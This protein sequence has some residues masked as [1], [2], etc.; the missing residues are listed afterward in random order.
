MIIKRRFIIVLLVLAAAFVALLLWW[1][2]RSARRM[3]DQA[4]P[5][6][7]P[8]AAPQA[9]G[10]AAS[11][12]HRAPQTEQ[13]SPS[14][15]RNWDSRRI[16]E[17]LNHNPIEFYGRAL[18]Q[19]GEPVA[20]AEVRGNL[21]YNTGS[22]AGEKP[23]KTITNAQGYFQFGGLE[24]QSLSIDFKKTG[25][26]FS[27]G[28]Q[29]T[30]FWYSYFEADH[31]RHIPDPK[32]P[33]IFVLWKEQGAE[34]LVHYDIDRDVPAD[35]TPVGINLET[36]RIGGPDTD[37]VVTIS[38]TPLRMRFGQ[39]GFSWSATVEV[40]GG[41]LIRA[42]QRDYYNLAPEAGY[43]SRFEFT[44]EAQNVRGPHT[45]RGNI[46]DDFFISSR[47]GKNF[48]RIT[49]RLMAN[50]DRQEG[51]N[52]GAVRTIVWLNPNRSRNLEFDPAKAIRPPP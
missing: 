24:G 23:T 26:E 36:G 33:V 41:G 22:R 34:P 48:A 4:R 35:G 16:F 49:L 13:T 50:A 38:R 2:A 37:L 25:Y 52:I 39:M 19:F 45:W 15:K 43:V 30:L 47:L 7:S 1:H 32:N 5:T 44:Q 10:V 51:D 9:S 11:N 31:K 46:A 29:N 21:I 27:F 6:Q 18:D 12:E 28:S 40:V 17:T 8:P 42:G 3:A 14:Q 20:G